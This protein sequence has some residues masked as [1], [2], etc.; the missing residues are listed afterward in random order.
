[1]N[2]GHTITNHNKEMIWLYGK[3]YVQS[4]QFQKRN[5]IPLYLLYLRQY[6]L[7]LFAIYKHGVL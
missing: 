7:Y 5:Y 6:K 3:V 4:M 2:K 1:M